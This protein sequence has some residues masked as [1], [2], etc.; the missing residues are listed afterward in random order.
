MDRW[1]RFTLSQVD[2]EMLGLNGGET[3]EV[4]L[5]FARAPPKKESSLSKGCRLTAGGSWFSLSLAENHKQAGRWWY[6]WK[7]PSPRQKQKSDDQKGKA[8]KEE[9]CDPDHSGK[10][11]D[12]AAK[13][14]I[15]RHL[16]D[17]EKVNFHFERVAI[18]PDDIENIICLPD[19]PKRPIQGVRNLK[20]N[21]SSW[22]RWTCE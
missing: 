9:R 8:K 22:T 14:A 16:K 10:D 13:S 18:L 6:G 15:V 4:S 3:F 12:R 2:R 20:A 5:K 7:K 17:S 11:I 1:G 19:R 21:L